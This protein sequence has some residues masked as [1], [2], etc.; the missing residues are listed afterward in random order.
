MA[1]PDTVLPGS[2]APVVNSERLDSVRRRGTSATFARKIAS[3]YQG[4]RG[5]VYAKH[6]FLT[7]VMVL[8]TRNV[9]F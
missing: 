9:G 5:F 6:A 2:G 3:N 8:S 4:F 1:R 7:K